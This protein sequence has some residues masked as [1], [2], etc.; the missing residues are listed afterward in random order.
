MGMT[1][2]QDQNNYTPMNTFSENW[3]E[4]EL[5]FDNLIPYL[6]LHKENMHYKPLCI[7]RH[8]ISEQMNRVQDLCVP[9]KT[10]TLDTYLKTLMMLAFPLYCNWDTNVYHIHCFRMFLIV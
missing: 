6:E 1:L 5:D 3:Q 10:A 9:L 2:N 8:S 7:S 4:Y